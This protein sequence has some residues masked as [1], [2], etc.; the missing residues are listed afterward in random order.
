MTS[1]ELRKQRRAAERKARKL[2]EKTA[3]AASFLT[4][5][6]APQLSVLT[7]PDLE[8]FDMQDDMQDE[9]PP[10]FI[11]EANAMRARVHARAGLS[12]E[13]TLTPQP[14]QLP[15]QIE[16]P[17]P[18]PGRPTGPRTPQG[19][20]VSSRNSFKHGL[21]SSEVIVPGEKPAEFDALVEDLLREHQ[22]ANVTEDLLVREMAQSWWLAQ[23]AL[24]LQNA[25]FT[26]EGVDTRNL[27]LFLRYQ[28]THERAFHKALAVLLRLQKDRRRNAREFVSQENANTGANSPFS[29]E[30]ISLQAGSVSLLSHEDSL[31]EL[32][33][34]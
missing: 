9:F 22:P 15:K 6:P 16:P 27:A 14:R 31:W 10:E 24:R 34:A 33:A 11:A 25:C 18:A 23:R 4:G 19:K 20:S 21:A 2:Q 1:R 5:V 3:A 29:N 17:A 7:D 26:E 12:V 8:H 28:T 30:K 13:P 32:E